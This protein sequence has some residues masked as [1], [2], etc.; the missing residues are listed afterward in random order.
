MSR[1]IRRK[2]DMRKSAILAGLVGASIMTL[3]TGQ[4]LG[5]PGETQLAISLMS[6]PVVREFATDCPRKR[7]IDMSDQCGACSLTC[8]S[9]RA[10]AVDQ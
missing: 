3:T 5:F 8:H 6:P 9:C 7:S 2:F 1:V 10:R 4:A